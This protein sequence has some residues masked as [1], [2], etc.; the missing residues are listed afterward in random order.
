MLINLLIHSFEILA[1]KP[2]LDQLRPVQIKDWSKTAVSV[3][4]R[5]SPVFFSSRIKVDRSRSRSLNFGPKNRTGPD[6]QAL[7]A[8]ESRASKP[9]GFSIAVSQ[10]SETSGGIE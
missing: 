1:K 6:F 10:S 9:L 5:S 3:F 4:L 2:V 8:T 7:Q